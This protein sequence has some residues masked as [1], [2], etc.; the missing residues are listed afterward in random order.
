MKRQILWLVA[1]ILLAS[2]MLLTSC[3]TGDNPAPEPDV[4]TN[5]IGKALSEMLNVYDI[6]KLEDKENF[7]YKETF[8]TQQRKSELSLCIRCS[9]IWCFA[10]LF[11]LLPT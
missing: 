9:K 3:S 2:P 5:P 10:K 6:V 1:A 11:V 4:V 7:G 8:A